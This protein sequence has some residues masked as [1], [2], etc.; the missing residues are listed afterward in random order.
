MTSS[1]TTPDDADLAD[2]HA[3]LRSARAPRLP[4][5][6]GWS[7]G[8]DADT[9]AD[10]LAHWRDAYDWR[11]HETRIQHLAWAT[12]GSLNV[13]HQP[14]G[15]PGAPTV[16]LLHGWPDSVLRFE[17]VL[18]LLDDVNVV[19]PAL[20]GFPF[21]APLTATGTTTVTMADAVAEAMRELGYDRYVVSGGDVGADVAEHLAARH[22]DHVPALH[23]TN[24]SPLHAVFADRSALD[25]ESLDYLD[26]VARWSRAEGAY[27]AEQSS[28]PHTLA[29]AL[30]DSP[31]GL[32]AWIYEKLHNWSE[33]PPSVDDALT[34]ISA[35]WHTDTIGSSF[36][37]YAEF[38]PPV[39]FVTTPTVLSSFA[40]DTK[41]APRSFAERFVDVQEFSEHEHGGHFAAWEQPQL[42][43]DD[44]RRA[45]R[46]AGTARDQGLS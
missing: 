30:A 34:W 27:I 2:L 36:A 45:L 40:Y 42:Y 28:K 29:V 6:T 16:V 41:P 9:L 5:G 13:L 37:T 11:S 8:V 32:A 19:V 35:Y 31:A 46:I 10:L 7:R 26:V 21:A 14:A 1:W 4:S 38:A 20:P 15:E 43:V 18:P 22:A 39:S 24:I 33:Q 3:R 17:R 44:L 23:L 25:A 12:A